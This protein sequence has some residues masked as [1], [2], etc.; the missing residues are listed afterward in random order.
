MCVNWL[1]VVCF[2]VLFPPKSKAVKAKPAKASNRQTVKTKGYQQVNMWDVLCW[3]VLVVV[4]PCS[5]C[6]VC[7][8]LSV[9]IYIYIPVYIYNILH[10]GYGRVITPSLAPTSP[11]NVCS[12]DMCSK[13][14]S[15][16]HM[17]TIIVVVVNDVCFTRRHHH[18]HHKRSQL[19]D[20]DDD[21]RQPQQHNEE[22]Q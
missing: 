13:H 14:I 1:V 8:S 15:M 9:H 19:S 20:T 7:L 17:R 12:N 4:V 3:F 5:R 11:P 16:D 6:F 18:K 10:P 21:S 22:E 2:V